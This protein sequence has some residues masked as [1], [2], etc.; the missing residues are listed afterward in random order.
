MSDVIGWASSFILLITIAVQVR[1]QWQSG[2]NKG[3]SKWLF[4]GQLAA[5]V[6]FLIFSILTGSLVFTITNAML[7]LG[8]LCGIFIYFKNREI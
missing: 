1:R 4:I 2:S 5:S 3:V 6:G 8:N 7:T